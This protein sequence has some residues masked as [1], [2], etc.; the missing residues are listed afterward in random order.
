MKSINWVLTAVAIVFFGLQAFSQTKTGHDG[1]GFSAFLARMDA[2]QVEL[3]NGKPDA[4]KRLWAQTDDVTLSGGFG[5]AIE[6]GWAAVSKRL[7]WA[8]G[9]FSNGKNSIT[10][11][12]TNV[13]RKLAYV[14]QLERIDFVVPETGRPAHR[15]YRVT[16]IFR[17]D[18]NEWRIVHR[19]AD[20][21]T[22]RQPPQ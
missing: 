6:K 10:R 8:G 21:Q 22:S 16:M 7:D 1:D 14:V 13:D 2:A 4:Y 19:H 18:R 12:V 20:S 3:Q 15:D 17:R 9:N 11:L 5:G